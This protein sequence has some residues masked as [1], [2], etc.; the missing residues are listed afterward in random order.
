[1]ETSL[2]CEPSVCPVDCITDLQPDL[3]L[4][5]TLVNVLPNPNF[6][7]SISSSVMLEEES[8]SF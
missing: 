3:A 1:M 4:T 8:V 7:F 2:Y 6:S 5:F